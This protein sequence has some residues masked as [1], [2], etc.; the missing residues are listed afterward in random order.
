MV[1]YSPSHGADRA[2]VAGKDKEGWNTFTYI[3]DQRAMDFQ[4]AYN[5]LFHH[6]GMT[7]IEA[8]KYQLKLLNE[9]AL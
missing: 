4:N 5:Y 8:S 2:E 6:K 7:A 1:T 3:I 9:R